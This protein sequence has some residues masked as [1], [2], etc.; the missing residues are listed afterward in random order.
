ME[1]LPGFIGAHGNV[2]RF[3]RCAWK[4]HLLHPSAWKRVE[5]HGSAWMHLQVSTIATFF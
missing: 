4:W 2:A 1:V 3:N 5:A